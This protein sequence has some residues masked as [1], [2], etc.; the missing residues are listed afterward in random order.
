M[1]Q[2]C[3][4]SIQPGPLIKRLSASLEGKVFLRRAGNIEK[5]LIGGLCAYRHHRP[6][7][8]DSVFVTSQLT[9]TWCIRC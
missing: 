2:T 8:L 7:F 6:F 5:L 4:D 1:A 9:L 3:R